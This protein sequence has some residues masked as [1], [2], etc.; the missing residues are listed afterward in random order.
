ME[1]VSYSM[2]KPSAKRNK[3][4]IELSMGG[5]KDVGNFRKCI[6]QNIMPSVDSL[7]YEG[8]LYEYKFDTSTVGDLNMMHEQ[9]YDDSTLFYP[10]YCYAKTKKI[11]FTKDLSN[12]STNNKDES[13]SEIDFFHSIE[14]NTFSNYNTTKI[15]I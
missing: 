11:D 14:L 15:K 2:R 7:T 1:T 3:N 4:T 12:I 5:A 10:T 8:L 13:E 6:Q 9:K